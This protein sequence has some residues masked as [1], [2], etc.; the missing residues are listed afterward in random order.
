MKVIGS[1]HILFSVDYPYENMDEAS[2]WIETCDLS[3]NDR[4]K[5]AHGNAKKLLK[6]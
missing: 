3:E 4:S 6:L 2:N 1:D 5:I